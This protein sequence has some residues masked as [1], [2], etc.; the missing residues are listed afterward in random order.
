[1]DTQFVLPQIGVDIE[2]AEIR[3]WLKKEGDRVA[4]GD[5]IVAIGTPKLDMEV[6]APFAGVIKSI[7]A[8]DGEIVAVGAPLAVIDV[9]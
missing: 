1:M 7:I 3:Q 6:E 5:L 9:A 2:E 4:Q 8:K